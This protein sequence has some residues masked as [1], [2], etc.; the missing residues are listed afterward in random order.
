M[1]SQMRHDVPV[2][3]G[4]AAM[5]VCAGR[6]CAMTVQCLASDTVRMKKHVPLHGDVR[7]TKSFVVQR[8][9]KGR[10]LQLA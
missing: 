5:G 3:G 9:L 6:G 4:T 1:V 7:M 2:V 8:A 10:P